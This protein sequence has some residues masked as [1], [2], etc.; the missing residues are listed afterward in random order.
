MTIQGN[1]VAIVLQQSANQIA[2]LVSIELFFYYFKLWMMLHAGQL[3]LSNF[4]ITQETER[5][6]RK[7]FQ[8]AA[9]IPSDYEKALIYIYIYIEMELPTCNCR[10]I[11]VLIFLAC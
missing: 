9:G 10:Y 2:L 4:A 3:R 5:R 1:F 7:T 8:L 11:G 6:N